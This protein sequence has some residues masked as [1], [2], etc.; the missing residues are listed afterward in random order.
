MSILIL[1]F[2]DLAKK[3]RQRGIV[4]FYVSFFDSISNPLAEHTPIGKIHIKNSKD[5]QRKYHKIPF[6]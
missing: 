5:R 4:M 2:I 1:C 3:S 6:L